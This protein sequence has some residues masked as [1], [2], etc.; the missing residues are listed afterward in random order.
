MPSPVA[1]DVTLTDGERVQ[2]EAWARRPSSAQVLALRSRIVLCAAV[3]GL[4]TAILLQWWTNVIDYPFVISGND[5]E[6]EAAGPGFMVSD[7]A[8]NR[9]VMDAEIP[10]EA[11]DQEVIVVR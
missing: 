11:G 1:A 7:S 4:A 6:Q 5:Q 9:R 3:T 2:L 10:V 8:R